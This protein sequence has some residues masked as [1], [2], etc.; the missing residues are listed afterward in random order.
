MYVNHSF[1]IIKFKTKIMKMFKFAFPLFLI[2]FMFSSNQSNA[3]SFY[4]SFPGGFN[5]DNET[6]NRLFVFEDMNIKATYIIPKNSKK[7]IIAIPQDNV[8]RMGL[9]K[10]PANVKKI[11]G[12]IVIKKDGNCYK[13]GCKN[14]G[15]DCI[16]LWE[17]A[18]GDQKIQPRKELRC[19]CLKTNEACQITG[20][21]VSCTR[22]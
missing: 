17:D 3:Q 9:A 6:L 22:N 16:L 19:V 2:L 4:D 12:P 20:K 14:S 7:S 11:N 10:A 5:L 18:N 15:C 8:T 13:V 21:K 1:V